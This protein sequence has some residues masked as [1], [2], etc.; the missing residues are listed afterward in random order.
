[1]VLYNNAGEK[2]TDGEKITSELISFYKNLMGSATD[3][4]KPDMN[5]ISNGPCLNASQEKYLS[6]PVIRD[7]IKE[8]LFSIPGNKA[9]SPDGYSMSFFKSAWGII[10]EEISLAIEDFFKTGKLLGE[11]NSTSITLIPKVQCPRT[12]SDF[13]PIAC[14]NC[15][16]KFLSKNLTNRMK[17]LMGTLVNEA[18]SA[19]I[20][21]RQITSNILL[22]HELVK[23]YSGKHIS[24][25]VMLNI[26]IKKAFDTINWDFLKDM[27]VGLGFP[28]A[29][30][31]WIMA[32]I[33]SPKYSIALNRSLHGYFKGK[34]GLR[35]FSAVS[36]LEAN[37]SKRL[38]FLEE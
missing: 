24:L 7:E 4:V 36:S 2:L 6:D 18:Q 33:T 9:R 34:R 32:C 14:Y 5:I 1:M 3:T 22:A 38:V 13:R 10:G 19:F 23:N 29:M 17:S 28:E 16:Y 30:I 12:P 15:L 37:S 8:A 35:D 26:D 21:G 11:I 20:K 25:R 27:L 31:N